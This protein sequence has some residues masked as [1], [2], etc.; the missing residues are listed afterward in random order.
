MRQDLAQFQFFIFLA[1]NIKKFSSRKYV[2]EI[3]EIFMSLNFLNSLPCLCQKSYVGI[4]LF[5][6][7]HPLTT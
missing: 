6:L 4:K 2:D 7:T 5:F 3:G 1:V